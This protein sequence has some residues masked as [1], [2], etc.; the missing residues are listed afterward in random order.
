MGACAEREVYFEKESV[1]ELRA[2]MVIEYLKNN[3][4]DVKNIRSSTV[5]LPRRPT[6][7]NLDMRKK[8]TLDYDKDLPRGTTDGRM[9]NKIKN[10]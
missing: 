6:T 5:G 1:K 8:N 3:E 9:S 2:K 7:N 4:S 10:P